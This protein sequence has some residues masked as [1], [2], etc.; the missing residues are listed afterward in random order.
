M[1]SPE[2][3]DPAPTDAVTDLVGSSA[4][5]PAALRGSLLRGGSY[6]GTVLLSLISAP[7]LI[8]HLGL[9]EFGRYSTVLAVVTVAGGLTDAGLLTI[10]VREWSTR[11]AADRSD[12][13]RTLLGM[14]LELSTLGLIGGVGFALLAGYDRVLVIG[15]V[16]AGT[17]MMLQVCADMLTAPLQGELRF[18]W[19]SLIDLCRQLTLVLAIVALVLAGAPLQPFFAVMIPSSGLALILAATLARRQTSLTPKLR[20]GY[21]WTLLRDTLPFS[22][23]AAVNAFYFQLTII[24][25]ELIA[26]PVQTG[27]FATS[28]RIT[29]VLV[30]IPGLAIGTAFPILSRSAYTDPERF[31]NAIER[32]LEL[33]VMAGVAVVLCVVL[34]APFAIHVLA[35]P[36]GAPA[37]PVLQIQALALLA[38]FPSVA[39][40]YGLLALRRN[41]AVLVAN[42]VALVM[43]LVLTLVLV[44]LDHARGAAIAAV[45]AETCLGGGQ[46][47]LLLRGGHGR[48]RLRAMITVAF[49]GAVG[50]TPLLVSIHPLLRTIWGVAMY[51]AVLAVLRQLPPEI[52][53]ILHHRRGDSR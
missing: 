46:V 30:G 25:M 48:L 32:I 39:A 13:M 7:L 21:R 33:A 42:V 17:G 27:Y 37:T 36:K 26:S 49:A 29:Q 23:A 34:I 6:A 1:S 22:A 50:A 53:H 40:G 15:T 28:F 11:P 44:P 52:G 10:T 24:V 20:G 14:R 2:L 4:A 18:G 51:V 12:V 31:R 9:V 47:L 3:S 35:G 8:R 16:L 45:I 43:N 41:R 19:A 5:G 38:T